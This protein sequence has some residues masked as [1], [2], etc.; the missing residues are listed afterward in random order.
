MKYIGGVS[1]FLVLGLNADFVQADTFSPDGAFDSVSVYAGHG[2]DHNLRE[3]PG[4]VIAGSFDWEKAYFAAVGFGKVRGTLGEGIESVRGSAIESFLHGYETVLVK[5][6]GLQ[7][8]AEV[9]AAYMLKT[10]DLHLGEL[11]VNFG[12]GTGL[13]Y[14]LGTPSYEDGPVND[15]ARRYRLQL[16]VLFDFE[17]H[18][19]GFDKLSIITRIHHRCGVYGL[20]APRHVGSNFMVAG[21]RHRF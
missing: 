19:A 20:I 9:G 14:A 1:A 2:A 7:H 5:H 18:V 6:S 17:W 13:S 12:V 11:G 3:L 21:I 10:S 15:P 4:R 8:N 16:L